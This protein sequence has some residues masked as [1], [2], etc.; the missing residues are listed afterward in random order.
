MFYFIPNIQRT[1]KILNKINDIEQDKTQSF[2][3]TTQ[4]DSL[5]KKYEP[6][7]QNI[8]IILLPESKPPMCKYLTL[9]SFPG[10]QK[11][12]KGSIQLNWLYFLAQIFNSQHKSVSLK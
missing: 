8:F 3:G 2:T 9:P 6:S 1:F 4:N 10:N 11:I 12:E 5:H 7:V